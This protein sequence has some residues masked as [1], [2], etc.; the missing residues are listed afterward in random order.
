MGALETAKR[1]SGRL[2]NKA[3]LFENERKTVENVKSGIAKQNN[4]EIGDNLRGFLLSRIEYL[5]LISYSPS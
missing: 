2:T 3:V 4:G 1:A 5:Q